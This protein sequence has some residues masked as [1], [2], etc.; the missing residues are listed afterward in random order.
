MEDGGGPDER[1]F[2]HVIPEV[3]ERADAL[4]GRVLEWRDEDTT[5]VVMSDHG[6]APWTWKVNLNAW[7]V[8]QG[9]LTP[10]EG[11]RF[12]SGSWSHVDWARTKAYGLG[13]NQIFLN[14]GGP[15]GHRFRLRRGA[16]SA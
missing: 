8:E 15:R 9:H 14:P 5:V 3:Y 11:R 4:V 6:F 12:R 1:R 7:L 10:Y 13:I 16:G 2:G